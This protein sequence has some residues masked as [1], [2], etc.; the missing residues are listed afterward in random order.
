MRPAG[1]SVSSLVAGHTIY[2][3]A[4]VVH[5]GGNVGVGTGRRIVMFT[6]GGME[7]FFLEAGAADAG[8]EI[9]PRAA[10]QSALRHGWE[11][12]S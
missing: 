10:L 11:F 6:P 3:P 2:V 7:K 8:E 12:V 5:S 9:D 1:P 4:D